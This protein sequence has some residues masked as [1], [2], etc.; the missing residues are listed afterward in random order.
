MPIGNVY[1]K[2]EFKFLSLSIKFNL[3]IVVLGRLYSQFPLKTFVGSKS[4]ANGAGFD[5]GGIPVKY[6]MC[7][8]KK[9]GKMAIVKNQERKPAVTHT[10]T[11]KKKE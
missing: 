2:T 9:K 1:R 11:H 4:V 7:R 5:R 8:K 6:S 10:H 3:A